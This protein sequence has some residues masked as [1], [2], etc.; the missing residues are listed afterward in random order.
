MPKLT[1]LKPVTEWIGGTVTLLA[2]V[3]G[4]GDAP[5]RPETL[6][7]MIPSGPVLGMMVMKPGASETD[8]VE[9]FLETTRKPSG[10]ELGPFRKA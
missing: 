3:T 8:A 5:Y 9:H 6:L 1:P 7:W 4:E 2:Y 10:K